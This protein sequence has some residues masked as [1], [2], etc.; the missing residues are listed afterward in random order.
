MAALEIFLLFNHTNIEH[1]LFRNVELDIGKRRLL[2]NSMIANLPMFL[3][4]YLP[5]KDHTRF[6]R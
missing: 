3:I 1:N 6:R 2:L 5:H 4:R